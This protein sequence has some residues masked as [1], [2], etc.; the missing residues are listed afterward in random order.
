MSR[1]DDLKK[2]NPQLDISFIDIVASFDPTNSYKYL[3]FMIKLLKKEIGNDDPKK[4]LG[5]VRFRIR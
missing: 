4:I 1:I 3:G 2:Q 5:K